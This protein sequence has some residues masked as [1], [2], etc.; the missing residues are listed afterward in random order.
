MLLRACDNVARSATTWRGASANKSRY[1]ANK[2]RVTKGSGPSTQPGDDKAA[3]RSEH[4]GLS[5]PATSRHGSSTGPSLAAQPGPASSRRAWPAKHGPEPK[6][7]ETA[8]CA[9]CGSRIRA[10]RVGPSKHEP[11]QPRLLV[12]KEEPAQSRAASQNIEGLLAKLSHHQAQPPPSPVVTKPPGHHKAQ[13]LPSPVITK[14]S[15]HRA[16]HG[17]LLYSFNP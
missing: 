13:S 5:H 17:F 4:L 16:Q 11:A 7:S 3:C 6:R 14:T 10:T 2:S 9:E 8:G 12:R 15:R 1:G